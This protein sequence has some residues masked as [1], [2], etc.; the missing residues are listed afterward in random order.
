MV[1]D[2]FRA[3]QFIS[4][5]IIWNCNFSAWLSGGDDQP[6]Q[7]LSQSFNFR[8]GNLYIGMSLHPS[9]NSRVIEGKHHLTL[10]PALALTRSQNNG[11]DS[12]AND[13]QYNHIAKIRAVTYVPGNTKGEENYPA[14]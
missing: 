14:Q 8:E 1:L 4:V 3:K 12:W 9:D 5:N 10:D 13:H 11:N 7:L 6:P 2:E